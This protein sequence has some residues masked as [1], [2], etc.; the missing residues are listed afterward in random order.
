MSTPSC[1]ISASVLPQ[2]IAGAVLV[3]I[4]FAL[5]AFDATGVFPN[6]NA[7]AILLLVVLAIIAF[8]VHK[9][10]GEWPA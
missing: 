10:A 6:P 8:A 7:S 3:L 5:I 4:P 1:K 9:T 2:R